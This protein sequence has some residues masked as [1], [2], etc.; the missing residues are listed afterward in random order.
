MLKIFSSCDEKNNTKEK[1]NQIKDSMLNLGLGIGNNQCLYGFVDVVLDSS[2][3]S[4]KKMK[5]LILVC[6]IIALTDALFYKYMFKH[7]RKPFNHKPLTDLG[8]P[9]ILTPY[10][11]NNQI[12]EAQRA[13]RVNLSVFQDIP[14]YAGFFTVDDQSKSNL[15]FWFFPSRNDYKNDPVILWLQ[16]GP[17]SSGLFGIFSEHGPFIVDSNL[18]LSIREISWNKNHS[19]IYIDQPVGTGFSFTSGNYLASQEEIG[20][21]LYQAVV[22]FFTLFPD[23]KENKFYIAGESYAGKFVPALGYTILQNNLEASLHVNLKGVLIGNGL[24]DPVHQLVYGNYLYQLGLIDKNQLKIFHNL[25]QKAKDYVTAENYKMGSKVID[26]ILEF[27]TNCTKLNNPYN[28][29]EQDIFITFDYQ[30]FVVQDD[31]RRA[32]NVGNQYYD[33]ESNGVYNALV[34]DIPKSVAPWLA[35]LINNYKVLLYSGQL[36]V[37]V[38]YPLTLNYLQKLSFNGA[39]EYKTASR[40]VWKVNQ[41]VAGYVKYGG[42]LTEVLVGNASHFATRDQPENIYDML[43]KFVRNIYL[44]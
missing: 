15:F 4:R 17:G 24:T 43:F 8:D 40:N 42:N 44:I 41:S 36:D 1:R 20:L 16:G 27:Y 21:H 28:Y 25:E 37:I 32:I 11:K 30:K 35:E 7:K 6:S 19:V 22:Q 13:A 34:E 29:L 31:V 3:S 5:I 33:I 38:A 26:E 12:E 14:S 23:L 10:L 9:L 39:D 18:N 2:T